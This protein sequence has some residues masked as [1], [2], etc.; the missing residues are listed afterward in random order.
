MSAEAP[1]IRA[2]NFAKIIKIVYSPP[3]ASPEEEGLEEATGSLLTVRAFSFGESRRAIPGEFAEVL[4]RRTSEALQRVKITHSFV[5]HILGLVDEALSS[6]MLRMIGPDFILSQCGIEMND[7]DIK[8]GFF[9]DELAQEIEREAIRLNYPNRSLF[10]VEE[11]NAKMDRWV[12]DYT[13]TFGSNP[14]E[15]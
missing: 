1:E 4:R 14:L 2:A 11:H 10:G 3:P 5:G 7:A 12:E 6:G 13:A 9:V 8:P 15:V